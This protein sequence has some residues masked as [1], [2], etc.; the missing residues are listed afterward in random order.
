MLKDYSGKKSSESMI[1]S[2]HPEKKT[3]P[4]SFLSI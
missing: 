4:E 2:H 1:G 3:N